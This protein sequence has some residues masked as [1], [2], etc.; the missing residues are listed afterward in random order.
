MTYVALSLAV[1]ALLA[2]VTLR[3]LRPLPKRPLLWTAIVL[4]ALTAVFD[5]VIVGLGIVEY[6][7]SKISGL[8]LWLAPIEDFAYALG[9]VLLIPVLWTWLGP[10]KPQ[11]VAE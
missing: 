4:I 6:D 2:V 7:H 9:A 5:N 10:T 1:L 8:L 3:T 11:R